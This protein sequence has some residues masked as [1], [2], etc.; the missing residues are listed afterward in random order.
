MK[1][2]AGIP[3]LSKTAGSGAPTAFRPG[4]GEHHCGHLCCSKRVIASALRSWGS[5]QRAAASRPD[6]FRFP[7]GWEGGVSVAP[8]TSKQPQLFIR[9][10]CCSSQTSSTLVGAH[11]CQDKQA[12]ARFFSRPRVRTC[13]RMIERSAGTSSR[14]RKVNY[15]SWNERHVTE[16][17]QL[18]GQKRK[19]FA[20]R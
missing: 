5:A 10:S 8:F 9:R 14:V 16:K 7:R 15:S 1:T 13:S 19:H 4:A 17:L 18:C 20:F 12:E 6:C 3:P 11:V 2:A